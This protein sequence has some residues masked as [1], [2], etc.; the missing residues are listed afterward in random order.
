MQQ[1]N[2][3]N[4]QHVGIIKGEGG[5]DAIAQGLVQRGIEVSSFVFTSASN[6]PVQFTQNGGKLATLAALSLQAKQWRTN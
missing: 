5:R 4:C 2:E 6:L 3:P 1:L